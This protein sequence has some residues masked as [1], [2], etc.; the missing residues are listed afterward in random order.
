MDVCHWAPQTCTHSVSSSNLES[1]L[2]ALCLQSEGFCSTSI[3]LEFQCCKRFG[4]PDY[5]WKLRQ[6]THWETQ[7]SPCL[8]KSL[9]FIRGASLLVIFHIPYQVQFH[10]CLS[11]PDPISTCPDNIPI[12]L[13]G[14]TFMFHCLH[15]SFLYLSLMNR[16]LLS[17]T[18]LLP[19]LLD[20]M[21]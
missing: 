10:L 9:S 15:I 3:C 13:Q 5:Q 8:L 7:P 16:S 17:H 19:P 14:H 6:I 2:L 21:H 4:N 18:V 1:V 11:F 12:F 20:F